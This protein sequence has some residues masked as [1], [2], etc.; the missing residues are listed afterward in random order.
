MEILVKLLNKYFNYDRI[1]SNTAQLKDMH[2]QIE[3]R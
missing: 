3:Q 1:G 2:V